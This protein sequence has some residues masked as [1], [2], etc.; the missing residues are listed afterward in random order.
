MLGV[1]GVTDDLG[2]CGGFWICSWRS[3]QGFASIGL[4][5]ESE[6][7]SV[8]LSQRILAVEFGALSY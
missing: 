2:G 1:L 4:Q 3:R 6:S 5:S 7:E 8:G